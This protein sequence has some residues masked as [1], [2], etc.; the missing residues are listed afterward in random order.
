VALFARG[1]RKNFR[2]IGAMIAS[3]F[4]IDMAPMTIKRILDRVA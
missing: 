3:E 2:E 4:E 1:E